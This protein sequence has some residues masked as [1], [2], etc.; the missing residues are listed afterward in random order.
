M[1]KTLCFSLY[2]KRASKI[3]K[4]STHTEITTSIKTHT[5]IRK[6]NPTEGQDN[7]KE[8]T[9]YILGLEVLQLII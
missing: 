5:T 3:G 2:C 1:F 6:S 9:Y 8:K 4:Y 7:T